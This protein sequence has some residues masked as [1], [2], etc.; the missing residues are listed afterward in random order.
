MQIG[1]G[2]REEPSTRK[3]SLEKHFRKSSRRPAISQTPVGE[4]NSSSA[5]HDDDESKPDL[6]VE[7]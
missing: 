7:R 6:L 1:T 4:L 3:N 2:H 5:E